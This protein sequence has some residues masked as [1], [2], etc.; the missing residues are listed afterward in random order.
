MSSSEHSQFRI[1]APLSL[2]LWLAL[3]FPADA[4]WFGFPDQPH[5]SHWGQSQSVES[6]RKPH[7]QSVESPHPQAVE[8]YRKPPREISSR[9]HEAQ[10]EQHLPR[11]PF[12]IIVAT[13]NQQVSVFG[14]DGLIER[15]PISTGMPTH[16]T[17]TGV[18]TVISKAK[19][20]ESN[21]YSRAPMPYMQR[22]TWSGIALHAGPRPGY[23]ASHGCIR[24]PQDFAVRL[25]QMT[26]I[27]TRVIVTRDATAPVEITHPKLFIPKNP[28]EQTA[29]VTT[30]MITGA[31]PIAVDTSGGSTTMPVNPTPAVGPPK[32]VSVFVS[33]K[34][35]KVFVRRGFEEL[36]DV[37]IRIE[38]T[39]L[40]IGTHIFTA[41]G[42]KDGGKTMRWTVVSVPSQYRHHA[43]HSGKRYANGQ[44]MDPEQ[45]VATPSTASKALDRI[46][47]PSEAIEQISSLLMVG[48]SLIISDNALSDET[49]PDTGFIVLTP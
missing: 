7:P 21:I 28:A 10:H 18:F 14:Q 12:E 5:Y 3:A 13:A 30:N 1:V 15:A 27:G 16:P 42:L 24:L 36:F 43:G 20:H 23:P 39:D 48:S 47:W 46:T 2:A 4:D 35:R 44:A 26:K 33:R 8:S 29:A 9:K 45:L 17:P 40:P 25:F 37:P 6:H 32:P 22:I 31:T 19:W 11:G 41:M 38:E 34:Q 49:D